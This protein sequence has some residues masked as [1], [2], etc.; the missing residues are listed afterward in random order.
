MR[1]E[2]MST[3]EAILSADTSVPADHRKTILDF[4]RENRRTSRARM[5]TAKEA[6]G[7][8]GVHPRTLQRWGREGRLH[9]VSYTP[10]RI[11]WNEGE[12]REFLQEGVLS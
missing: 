4:C 11:R 7:I 6:A 8:L 12:I 1:P 9:P 5:I 3:V 2:T 10:R